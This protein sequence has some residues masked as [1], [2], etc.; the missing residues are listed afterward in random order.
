MVFI[1]KNKVRMHDSDM[2][3]ILYFPRIYR[4]AHDALED[5]FESEGESFD[6]LFKKQEFVFVIVHSEADYYSSLKVGDAIEIHLSCEH[7]GTTSFTISYKIFRLPELTLMGSC[8]TIHVAVENAS[9]TKAPIPENFRKSLEK[10]LDKG[11]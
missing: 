3:G 6:H 2:A 1:S 7:I 8:K 5:F 11:D 4:F 10:Y 9:R